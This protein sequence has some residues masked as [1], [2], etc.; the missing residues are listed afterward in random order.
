MELVGPA[1][2][3][4]RR[5]YKPLQRIAEMPVRSQHHIV[6]RMQMARFRAKRFTE[7]AFMD[8]NEENDGPVFQTEPKKQRI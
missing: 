7:Q 8:A 4:V 5:V 2:N 6:G 3:L 1:R